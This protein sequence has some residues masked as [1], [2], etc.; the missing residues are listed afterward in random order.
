MR[1]SDDRIRHISHLIYDHLVSKTMV[2][3]SDR[4]IATHNLKRA[5][6]EWFA[7]DDEIEAT[8]RQKIASIKRGVSEG[9]SEWQALYDQFTREERDKRRR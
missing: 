1:F 3:V 9:T 2:T 7:V 6:N 8:V 5:M 4:E